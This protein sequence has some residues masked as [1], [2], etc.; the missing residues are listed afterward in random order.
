MAPMS[1]VRQPTP[2][3]PADP[4]RAGRE[5]LARHAWPEAF[6]LLSEADRAG[7][8]TAADLESLAIAAFFAA[9]ADVEV[10]VKE[11]AFKAYEAEGNNLRAAFLA[12]DIARNYG[13]RGKASI[14]SAWKGRAER[15]IDPDGDTYV[16][17]YLAL[18][19][20]EVAASTGDLDAA[21]ALAE[22]AIAIGSAT[23]D[24][25]LRAYSQ[26]NLGA[27]KIAS[28]DTTGGFALMEEAS[29]AA[30]NGELSPF[31][32]GV[33]ACRMIGACRDLT[34]YRRASEWIEATEKYCD[35]N[36]LEGFPGVC[37]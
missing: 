10:D 9:R 28:G 24:P 33:T 14:A 22:R 4:M 1:D 34:D 11:R 21:L 29:I 35:R 36:S 17:G 31:T 8:L 32:S 37:R 26:T 23:A 25:D 16:H 18:V 15:L 5:A 30:V 27:L 2:A 6:E 3:A 13:F 19:A 20:S 7:E 12:V